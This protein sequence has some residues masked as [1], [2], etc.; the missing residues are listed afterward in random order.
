MAGLIAFSWWGYF[1]DDKWIWHSEFSN[2]SVWQRRKKE[3]SKKKNLK[4]VPNKLESG[5][6]KIWL[7]ARWDRS[8]WLESDMDWVN[9]LYRPRANYAITIFAVITFIFHFRNMSNSNMFI[10]D[11]SIEIHN[12]SRKSFGSQKFCLLTFDFWLLIWK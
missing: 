9:D 8:A 1:Y 10:I 12:T 2:T 3:E 6:A 7:L 5:R 11:I 4:P